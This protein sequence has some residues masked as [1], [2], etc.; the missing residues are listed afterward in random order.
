MNV[1]QVVRLTT[2]WDEDVDAV[3]ELNKLLVPILIKALDYDIQSAAVNTISAVQS[4][5]K[6]IKQRIIFFYTNK[7]V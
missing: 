5:V 6:D 3:N 2:S 1:R 4:G 7:H